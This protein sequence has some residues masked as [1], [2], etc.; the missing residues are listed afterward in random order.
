MANFRNGCFL[1]EYSDKLCP[2][3]LRLNPVSFSINPLIE[4]LVTCCSTC[5]SPTPGATTCGTAGRQGKQ[6]QRF[7]S[8]GG[9]AV[10]RL[11]ALESSCLGRISL[12]G[13]SETLLTCE[14]CKVWKDARNCVELRKDRMKISAHLIA[15]QCI[16]PMVILIFWGHNFHR[17]FSKTSHYGC[18]CQGCTRRSGR[19]GNFGPI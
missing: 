9:G 5:L 17:C 8:L 3:N 6:K 13:I 1:A 7:S 11:P 19:N 12:F 4:A 2:D 18:D 15:F 16:S 10:V 14:V